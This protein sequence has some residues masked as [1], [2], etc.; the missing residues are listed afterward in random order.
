MKEKDSGLVRQQFYSLSHNDKLLCLH[1]ATMDTEWRLIQINIQQ[2]KVSK[3]EVVLKCSKSISHLYPA[4][5]MVNV[6]LCLY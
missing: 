1:L 6:V 5:L 2:N 4:A 3:S